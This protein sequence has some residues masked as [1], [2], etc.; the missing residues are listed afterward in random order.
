MKI[1]VCEDEKAMN[2]SICTSL[3]NAGYH[4]DSCYD[5]IES[6]DYAL[7]G[8]YDLIIMD[9]MMPKMTGDHVVREIRSQG[10][11][12]PVIFLSSMSNYYAR[13]LDAG[14]D[15]FIEKPFDSNRLL[16]VIRKFI[17]TQAGVGTNVLSCADLSIDIG[18]KGVKRGD[19]SIHL[20]RQE[21]NFLEYLMSNKGKFK[22]KEDISR[23]LSPYE[24][25][26]ERTSN[27][28][29]V[30]INKLHHKID[31]GFDKQ[32]LVNYH[33]FGWSISED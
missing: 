18:K 8:D 30:V 15:Y 10:I 26:D 23:T 4:T 6:I 21:F 12:T 1:L 27:W 17:R 19:K 11:K 13:C 29:T 3:K 22:S 7:S 33:G 2:A 5:G 28:V 32:L 14:G 20:T 31:D 24:G 9:F 16:A 25:E